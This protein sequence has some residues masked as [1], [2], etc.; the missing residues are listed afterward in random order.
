MMLQEIV[1]VKLSFN[2][3]TGIHRAHLLDTPYKGAQMQISAFGR[4]VHLGNIYEVF[5][6]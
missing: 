2:H 5:I 3:Y 4:F 1:N 6:T